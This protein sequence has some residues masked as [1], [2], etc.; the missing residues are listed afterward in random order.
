MR[1]ARVRRQ[2]G[3][4]SSPTTFRVV[5]VDVVGW[6]R[7]TRKGGRVPIQSAARSRA[8]ARWIPGPSRNRSG[9]KW[10]A[11]SLVTVPTL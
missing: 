2:P 1:T 7:V 11:S 9:V 3:L 5:V 4:F 10:R 6:L 8:T